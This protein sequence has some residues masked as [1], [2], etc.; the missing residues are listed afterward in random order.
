MKESTRKSLRTLLQTGLGVISI[1][2]ILLPALGVPLAV[3]AG[4]TALAVSG[5]VAKFMNLSLDLLD[6]E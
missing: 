3:G 2:P 4:A 1:L 5:V 6:E